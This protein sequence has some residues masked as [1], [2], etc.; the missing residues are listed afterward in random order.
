MII[1]EDFEKKRNYNQLI[2]TTSWLVPG[3]YYENARLVAQIVDFV[4][5]LVYTWDR[6]TQMLLISEID[7]LNKLTEVY[8]LKYTVHLPVDNIENVRKAY[9]F[10]NGKL[11]ILNFVVHPFNDKDFFEIIENC[12]N[13]SVENLKE[14][15]YYHKRFVYDIGH[16]VLGTK[17]DLQKILEHGC[18]T[19]IHLMGIKDGKDHLEVDLKAFDILQRELGDLTFSTLLI[20]FEVFGLEELI[21]SII[22]WEKWIKFLSGD[23]FE[24][25]I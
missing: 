19:E 3:T 16:S 17:P 2:G 6:E 20:C 8:G 1:F 9:S 21:N 15:V 11:D 24:K 22:Q 13:V 4:E 25:D 7:K 5:L 18:I 23:E 14:K 12:H 10:L